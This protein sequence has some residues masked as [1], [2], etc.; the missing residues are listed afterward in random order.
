MFE[1]CK[2]EKVNLWF[3][4]LV[5]LLTFYIPI[6]SGAEGAEI[7]CPECRTTNDLANKFCGNCGTS[8]SGLQK[9]ISKEEEKVED[10]W[11]FK[12]EAT[13]DYGVTAFKKG[14]H[15]DAKAAFQEVLRKYPNSIYA[16]GARAWLEATKQEMKQN[17]MKIASRKEGKKSTLGTIVGL[18]ATL[19]LLTIL[20]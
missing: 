5:F 6:I 7:Y 1:E 11:E 15:T 17:R 16:P 20:F 9:T 14:M 4:A 3:L 12:A 2:W 18:G 10:D 19:L 13:F 8:L